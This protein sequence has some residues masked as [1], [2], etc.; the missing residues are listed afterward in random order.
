MNEPAPT[1][2]SSRNLRPLSPA[3]WVVAAV[4]ILIV[5]GWIVAWTS[6]RFYLNNWFAPL[7]FF[8]AIGVLAFF[9]AEIFGVDEKLPDGLRGRVLPILSVVPLL[10]FLLETVMRGW[11]A[12]L[13][14]GGSI[15]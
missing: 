10:G 7:S 14:V 12:F 1:P 3:E 11:A 8:G 2:S 4:A 9:V 15:A 13:T 5:V 6:T